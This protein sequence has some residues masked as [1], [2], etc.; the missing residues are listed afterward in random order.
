MSVYLRIDINIAAMVLLGAVF[1]IAYQRLDRKDTLNHRFLSMSLI[2]C[3][4]LLFETITCVINGHPGKMLQVLS[5]TLHTAL[6]L[7]APIITCAWFF[8]IFNWIVPDTKMSSKKQILLIIPV[9]FNAII[10]LLSPF[11]GWVFFI[12]HSNVYGRGS[13]FAISLAITYLYLGCSLVLIFLKREMIIKHEFLP[14]SA[15]GVLPIL[16]GILQGLF[17]GILLMWSSTAFSLI[18]VYIF[19]QQRM[20]HLDSLTGAWTRESLNYYLSNRIRRGMDAVLG[21]IY[22]DLDGL[23]QIND[24]YGHLEGDDAIKTTIQLIKS[25]LRKTDI[26]AR[27]GGDEFIIVVNCQTNE[28]L[29]KLIDRI[30]GKLMD[31]NERSRKEY[32]LECSFG[33]DIFRSSDSSIEQFIRQIDGLMYSDKR[34]KALQ[35]K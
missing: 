32:K 30:K 33:S 22:L 6:Y 16:G 14:L 17:Y 25:L 7:S 31:Y 20:I 23:K 21:A 27:V 24:R 8:F 11:F 28:V 18:I 3:M 9:I 12:T 2:I 1:I 35:S 4:E 15:V 13:L 5:G 34:R 10:T 29:E 19:L 26:I